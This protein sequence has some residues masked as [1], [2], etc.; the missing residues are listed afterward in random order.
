MRAD[1]KFNAVEVA[2]RPTDPVP[3]RRT[4]TFKH[5]LKIEKMSPRDLLKMNF[6]C[7][8]IIELNTVPGNVI[9]V[10]IVDI[11]SRIRS[12]SKSATLSD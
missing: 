2:T 10:L 9:A 7:A 6:W 12:L 11:Q 5:G 8:I 3:H 4:A 1:D